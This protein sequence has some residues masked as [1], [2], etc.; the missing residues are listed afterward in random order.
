M[1]VAVP[2]GLDGNPNPISTPQRTQV[3]DSVVQEVLGRRVGG[4]ALLMGI[5]SAPGQG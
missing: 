5:S 1:M 2:A 4:T 3:L